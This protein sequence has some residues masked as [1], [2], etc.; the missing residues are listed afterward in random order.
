[1]RVDCRE[2]VVEREHT[3]RRGSREEGEQL[4]EVQGVREVFEL[5]VE[6]RGHGAARKGHGM[7]AGEAKGLQCGEE[8]RVARVGRAHLHGNALGKGDVNQ[9]Q[10]GV[11]VRVLQE[12]GHIC[13][14]VG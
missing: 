8:D 1:M 13:S 14:V 6:E 12:A 7:D 10:H 2:C 9:L 3:E 4:G 5:E 11:G